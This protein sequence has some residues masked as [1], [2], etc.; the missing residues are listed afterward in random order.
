VTRL[1]NVILRTIFVCGSADAAVQMRCALV[2]VI[3]TSTVRSHPNSYPTHIINIHL[4]PCS[5]YPSLEGT[6]LRAV[7]GKLIQCNH[8]PRYS[9]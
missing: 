8:G 3:S 9:K 2:F 1:D 6:Y 5:Y 4:E 7:R